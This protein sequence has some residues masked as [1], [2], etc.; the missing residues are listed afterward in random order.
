MNAAT[1]ES[2]GLTA[3][4]SALLASGL[5]GLIGAGLAVAQFAIKFVHD[6]SAHTRT[7][8]GLLF[9][10]LGLLGPALP[11]L[12][13]LKREAFARLGTRRKW[14]VAIAIPALYGALFGLCMVASTYS[15]TVLMGRASLALLVRYDPADPR[16]PTRITMH[17]LRRELASGTIYP[18]GGDRPRRLSFKG[19]ETYLRFPQEETIRCEGATRIPDDGSVE[20]TLD[21]DAREAFRLRVEGLADVELTLGGVVVPDRT[22]FGRGKHQVVIKGN[23]K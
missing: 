15:K 17:G 8:W 12:L 22:R 4:R 23:P 13:F 21:F 11:L 1:R 10:A 18:D 3:W 19:Y 7:V 6:Q 14:A 9:M 2:R 20:I 16:R 5:A